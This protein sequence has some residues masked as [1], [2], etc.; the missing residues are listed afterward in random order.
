MLEIFQAGGA[1]VARS[2]PQALGPFSGQASCSWGGI[3]HWKLSPSG[4][5]VVSRMQTWILK[6]K[7]QGRKPMIGSQMGF[8]LGSKGTA[9]KAEA[10]TGC[11][12]VG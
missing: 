12:S 3:C 9:F 4:I 6:V 10:I 5:Q 7:K 8:I 1:L 11:Q 2:R